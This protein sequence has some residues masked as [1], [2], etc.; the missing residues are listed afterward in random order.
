LHA[1]VYLKALPPTVES[2]GEKWW[3]NRSELEQVLRMYG[4]SISE[5]WL[6]AVSPAI[7][8]FGTHRI[9]FGSFPALPIADLV[10]GR[11]EAV[12]LE[13]PISTDEWYAVLRKV[14]SELGEDGE[15]MTGVMGRNAAE[16]Y[17]L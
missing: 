6:K 11:E 8:T 12:S 14:I 9:I 7:E 16:V 2:G 13:Q 10:N 1:N 15:A 17:D 4:E 3:E 5:V